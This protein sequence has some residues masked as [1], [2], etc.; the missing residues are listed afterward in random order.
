M[1]SVGETLCGL[2]LCFTAEGKMLPIHLLYIYTIAIRY[3]IISTAHITRNV[4]FVG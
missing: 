2:P 3:P 1:D 4:T